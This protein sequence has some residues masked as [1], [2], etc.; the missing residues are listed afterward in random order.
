MP[1]TWKPI[2]FWKR[3][4]TPP[5]NWC[6]N[7]CNHARTWSKHASGWGRIRHVINCFEWPGARKAIVVRSITKLWRRIWKCELKITDRSR[8]AYELYWKSNKPKLILR[9]MIVS[10][11]FFKFWAT[12]PFEALCS[13]RSLRKK[14]WNH[15]LLYYFF[16]SKTFEYFEN[17]FPFRQ[18]NEKAKEQISN[19]TYRVSGAGENVGLNLR[20]EVEKEHYV[21]YSKSFY[22]AKILIHDAENF[23]QTSVTTTTIGQP[24]SDLTIA[25]IPSVIVSEPGIRSLSQKQ[26]NCLFDDEVSQIVSFRKISTLSSPFFFRKNF[27]QPTNTVSSRAWRSALWIRSYTNVIACRSIIRKRRTRRLRKIKCNVLWM[28]WNVCV[29]IDVSCSLF[30]RTLD[31]GQVNRFS[32]LFLEDVFSSLKPPDD[33][34]ALNESGVGM[35]CDCPPTCSELVSSK[36]K[37]VYE[38]G[39]V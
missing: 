8:V 18:K 17:P 4:A 14:N 13:T 16:K 32:C 3:W 38:C 19:P 11:I 1:C 31:S 10:K 6:R 26:R 5:I 28:T 15:W 30:C 7:W 9:L 22:G 33:I 23:P 27:D 2:W 37:L 29:T 25:V 21:A 34:A 24:G 39:L 20:I 12:K 36:F 35:V